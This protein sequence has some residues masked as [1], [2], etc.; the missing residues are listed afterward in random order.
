MAQQHSDTSA[1]ID[2]SGLGL[3]VEGIEL[4]NLQA[5]GSK[6]YTTASKMMS[7]QM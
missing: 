6:E 1:V 3:G 2:Q 5:T 7:D 4:S